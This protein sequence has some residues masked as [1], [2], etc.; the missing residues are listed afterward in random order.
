MIN[1]LTNAHA[2]PETLLSETRYVTKVQARTF[3]KALGIATVAD[4]LAHCPRRYE[5]RSRV[6]SPCEWGDG[7]NAV[8]TGEAT[9]VRRGRSATG[10]AIV[11]ASVLCDNER[12]NLLYFGQRYVAA[13]FERLIGER[14]VACGKLRKVARAT[15][16]MDDAEVERA[17]TDAS[18]ALFGRIVP[19]YPLAAGVTQ[20]AVRMAVWRMIQ[21]GAPLCPGG[22]TRRERPSQL[23][24][25]PLH[26]ALSEIHY[27][28][29]TESAEKARRSL[30]FE[31]ICG[32]NE[33]LLKARPHG[34]RTPYVDGRI[35]SWVASETRSNLPFPL[36]RAQTRV[37]A[38]CLADLTRERPMNRLIQG[39]VGSGKTVVAAALMLAAVRGGV[40]AALMAPTD[41][42][43]KQHGEKLNSLLAPW[44][45]PVTTL[46]GSTAP[47][48]RADVMRRLALGEPLV[49][50]GTVALIQER[51]QFA[52]LGLAIIDEQQRFGVESRRALR[53]KGTSVDLLVMTATPIPR[54][55]ALTLYGDLDVSTIDELPPGRVPIKTHVRINQDRE[56]VYSALKTVLDR[57]ER[58]YVVCPLVDQDDD[59]ADMAAVLSL[60]EDLSNGYLRGYRVSYAH[61]RLHA[62][63]LEKT[64]SDFRKGRI[65]VLVASTIVEVGVDV[66]EASVIIVE[67]AD[68]FGLSQLHQ[69]RG[70][71]GRSDRAGYCVLISNN[72]S[73]RSVDRLRTLG[74]CSDGFKIAEEDLRL[75]GQGDLEG[76]RQSGV[77][78]LPLLRLPDDIDLL[79]AA[80]LVFTAERT[81]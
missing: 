80:R 57:G 65:D 60:A 22:A 11:T 42:L 17:G 51:M 24:L 76:I 26:E 62:R 53:E 43:A 50:S 40:Q 28:S 64:V 34:V 20:R 15:Y 30:S 71:V 59:R 5:D 73:P 79:C 16:E 77:S 10:K 19:I 68:R 4:L 9:A 44:S 72:E 27:P 14:I 39:D 33:E 47:Q 23:D 29:S 2:A 35:A 3:E 69:L 13:Q 32:R 37:L 48:A 25:M 56:K 46:T 75:R 81:Q 36:T 38:E 49:V 70:R 7:E 21:G 54:T 66:P 18:S 61:G 12:V 58:A 74:R 78:A 31:M 8:I 1:C 55:L 63:D 6:L 52:N 67:S 41:L 45:V